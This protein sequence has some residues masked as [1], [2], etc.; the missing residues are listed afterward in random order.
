MITTN[1]QDWSKGSTES[2]AWRMA[3]IQVASSVGERSS[4]DVY[5]VRE[6]SKRNTFTIELDFSE[7][8]KLRDA[9]SELLD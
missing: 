8:C 6:G 5:L 7:A 1:Y 4:I 2:S 3:E 9:L